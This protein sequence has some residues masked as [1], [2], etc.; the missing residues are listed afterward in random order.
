MLLP[1]NDGFNFEQLV[2]DATA[3]EQTL[4]DE[5]SPPPVDYPPIVALTNSMA[6]ASME[7][8]AAEGNSS[9]DQPNAPDSY[10]R[11]APTPLDKA[12]SESDEDAA[13]E[14]RKRRKARKSHDARGKKRAKQKGEA[15]EFSHPKPRPD[16]AAKFVHSASPIASSKDLSKSRVVK[17]GYTALK[18]VDDKK[19]R[20]EY[21]LEELVGPNS[22]HKFRYVPWDGR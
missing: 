10:A 15:I 13:A 5:S 17:T 22:P 21:T 18:V 6:A 19:G 4:C 2:R 9:P 1:Y 3:L 7:P 20:R 14:G 16:F 11:P 8:Q 12:G